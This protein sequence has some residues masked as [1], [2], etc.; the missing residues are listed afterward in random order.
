MTGKAP[1]RARMPQ[2]ARTGRRGPECH[3]A[4]GAREPRIR[5]RALPAHGDRRAQPECPSLTAVEPYWPPGGWAPIDAEG[6]WCTGPGIP[7]GLGWLGPKPEWSP[8][9]CPGCNPPAD[10]ALFAIL[11]DEIEE[12]LAPQPDLFGGE[13]VEPVSETVADDA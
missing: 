2:D 3:R 9:S 6:N 4:R 12:H 7:T 8:P 11:A 13:S 1:R 10:R 5:R